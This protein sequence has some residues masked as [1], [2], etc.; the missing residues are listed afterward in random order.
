MDVKK[1][2]V[3][4]MAL[5]AVVAVSGCAGKQTTGESVDDD[6]ETAEAITVPEEDTTSDEDD[7]STLRPKK[8]GKV[9]TSDDVTTGSSDDEEE[10][11]EPASEEEEESESSSS[12]QPTQ[13]DSNVQM[14]SYEGPRNTTIKYS[15]SGFEP[16]ETVEVTM[17][18]LHY[19]AATFYSH[20]GTIP[21]SDLYIPYYDSS[22]A[23]Y[24][25]QIE[26]KAR[27][28]RSG[29]EFVTYYKITP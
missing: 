23:V 27:G 3:L 24:S 9:D 6:L 13:G 25:G 10:E 8:R 20:D 15:A 22:G 26:I 1:I 28:T 7:M 18:G 21:P 16:S 4:L 2:G 19:T 12:S 5:I 11:S 17:T 14:S 29:R